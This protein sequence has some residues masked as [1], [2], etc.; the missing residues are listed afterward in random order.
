MSGTTTNLD[1]VS[2][3]DEVN[4]YI[5]YV[6]QSLDPD[7]RVTEATQTFSG[8]DA[9]VKFTLTN[10][11]TL[12][13]VAWDSVTI[14]GVKQDF[15]S[16]WTIHWRGA[17]IGKVEFTTSPV[18]GTDNISI[19]YGYTGSNNNMVYPDYPRNDLGLSQYP[20][21]GF[22]I[23]INPSTAG[24]AGANNPIRNNILISLKVVD[25]D[26][27]QIDYL[28]SQFLEQI[29]KDAKQFYNFDYIEPSGIGPYDISED[30]VRN[31]AAK[32]TDFEA[33]NRYEIITF[34]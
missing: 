3:K 30:P 7:S 4:N 1:I 21:V 27:Y 20:R 28:T 31:V 23:R 11:A 19:T 26:T 9:T 34:S 29:K 13:Y 12:S 16:G 33:N 25:L 5:R 22:L 10:G 2:L 8:D 15:G 18:T 6:F 14:G 24:L 32:I 17:D